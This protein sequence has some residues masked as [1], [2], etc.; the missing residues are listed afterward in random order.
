MQP[1]AEEE[2]RIKISGPQK[3]AVAA[4]MVAAMYDASLDQ[5]VP[6]RWSFAPYP[7]KMASR[8]S[9]SPRHF[10]ESYL[11]R[12]DR[13]ARTPVEVPRRVY[14]DLEWF[15][16]YGF[17]PSFGRGAGQFEMLAAAPAMAEE[18][19][20]E[21]SKSADEE[22]NAFPA[23]D[24]TPPDP[25]TE[26]TPPPPPALR[27]NLKETVFFFPELMTDAGGDVI[28]KF[29]M[30]EALT[31]WK[32]LGFAHT[33]DLEFGLTEAEVVTQKELMVIPNRPRFMRAG[34]QIEFTAKVSNLT[35]QGLAGRASP[36]PF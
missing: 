35:E 25:E 8:R 9:W 19:M 34:D 30:N 12:S 14:R 28:L 29:T 20:A 5:F 24:L 17:G 4:E 26:T 11:R 36:A 22:A 23:G 2:W 3:D 13:G 6:N 18:D 16:F 7:V 27:T 10:S 31:R 21:R 15:G 1:G 33:S 32:L